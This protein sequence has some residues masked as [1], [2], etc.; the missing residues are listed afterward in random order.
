M[1]QVSRAAQ[2]SGS[3]KKVCQTPLSKNCQMMNTP[4]L[5]SC[6]NNPTKYQLI[7]EFLLSLRAQHVKVFLDKVLEM[8]G[9]EIMT[10]NQ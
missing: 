5:H 2:F 7:L 1:L 6:A 9:I 3:V 4:P 10:I 8:I